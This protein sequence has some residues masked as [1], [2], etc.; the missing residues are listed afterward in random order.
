MVV[1]FLRWWCDAGVFFVVV[2]VVFL[3]WC[4]C[5][6][7]VCCGAILSSVCSKGNKETFYIL[8]EVLLAQLVELQSCKALG[9]GLGSWLM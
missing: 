4:G 1:V 5:G 9:P 7:V 3:W 8:L 6:G 2:G